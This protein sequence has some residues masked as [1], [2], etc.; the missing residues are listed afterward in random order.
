MRRTRPGLTL[1]EV[2]VVIAIIGALIALL[3]PAVQQVRT[4]AARVQCANNL[5]QLGLALHMYNDTNGAFPPAL[6]TS[7]AN[8]QDAYATGFTYLLPFLE[9]DATYRTYH[10]D[11]PWYL[12]SNYQ[13]VGTSVKVFYCP[14]NR[15]QGGLDLAPIA[16]EWSTALPPFA[17]GCDY[18][19]CRGANGALPSDPRRIPGQVRGAFDVQPQGR[20]GVRLAAITDG[21]STTLALGDAAGGSP[22]YL[23]RDLN[24]PGQPAVDPLAGGPVP[25]EQAWGAASVGDK[26]HPWY[27]SVLAVTAQ[28]GLGPDPRDEPMNR[29]PATPT[30]WGGASAGDNSTGSDCI[31]GFRSLHV[32]GCNFL[33]CDGGVRFLTVGLSPDSYRALSTIAG[34]EVVSGDDYY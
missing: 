29:R 6:V 1:I 30:A 23:A 17:A 7:G 21:T 12:P 31:S 13:A 10:F 28:Y 24:N 16:A 22:V 5:H 15:E 34:G 26:S 8:V 33:F 4:A 19:F 3:L 14:A 32:G 18:A 2:L 25:L 9:Q 20:K 27:G 11:D